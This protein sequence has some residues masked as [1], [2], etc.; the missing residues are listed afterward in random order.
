M[1]KAPLIF[2][3]ALLAIYGVARVREN[4]ND[5]KFKVGKITYIQ[6]YHVNMMRNDQKANFYAEDGFH[7]KLPEGTE[8]RIIKKLTEPGSH[9]SFM[10]PDKLRVEVAKGAYKGKVGYV[11]RNDMETTRTK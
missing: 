11:S 4:V 9:Q 5:D 8:L 10:T 6:P 3:L 2:L 1:R 7:L